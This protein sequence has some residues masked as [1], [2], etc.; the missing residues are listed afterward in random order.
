MRQHMKIKFEK[1]HSKSIQ[2]TSLEDKRTN[3]Q[4]NI[5]TSR[6][7]VAAKKLGKKKKKKCNHFL[8]VLS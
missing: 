3:G 5:W 8:F 7:A 6:A 1:E 2:T 4:T